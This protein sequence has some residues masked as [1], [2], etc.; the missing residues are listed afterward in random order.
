VTAA[1]VLASALLVGGTLFGAQPTRAQTWP[2]ED[3]VQGE[4]LVK[5][6]PGASGQ[7]VAAANRRG[8]GQV[9]RTIPGIGVRVVDVPAG[10]EQSAVAAAGND[11]TNARFYPAAHSHVIAVGATND[12]D[13]KPK[14]SD[15]GKKWVDIGAPGVDILSTMPGDR[16]A[17]TSG[18]SMAT[19][20]VAG[21]AGLV[22]DDRLVRNQ[23]LHHQRLRPR[24]HRGQGRP[25]LRPQYFLALGPAAQRLQ[26]RR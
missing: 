8:G 6:E 1:L 2:P 3:F 5:F 11:H 21:V 10:H 16:Y 13:A 4:I 23:A 20:H 9:E 7:A 24:S 17:V 15:Y 14:F 12:R 26:E 22:G 18:T 19:P 25:D